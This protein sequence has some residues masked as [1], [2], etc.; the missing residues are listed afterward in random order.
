ML[1]ALPASIAFG[2]SIYAGAGLGDAGAGAVM[3][4]T[5]AAALGIVAP[6]VAR[7][8][9]LIS[10]PCAPAAAVLLALATQ[11]S[12][13]GVAAWQVPVLLGLT[14]L[15]AAFLQVLYGA[16]GGGRLIKFIPYQVVSGYMT[17]VGIIIVL[18]QLPKLLGLHSGTSLWQGV[19]SPL[20]WNPHAIAVGL[21]TMFAML[22]ALRL[23]H[24][25][26]GT[27]AGLTAGGLCYAGL[28]WFEPTLRT[29]EGNPLVI[30]ALQMSGE[31]LREAAQRLYA[32]EMIP[33]GTLQLILV[34][35]VTLSLL[36]S[37][38]TL[39]TCVVLDTITL[40]RHDAN[41]ELIGQGVGNALSCAFGGMPGAGTM[42]PTLVN[43]TS[44]GRTLR[45]GVIEGLL[46][47]GVLLALRDLIAWLP[48]PSLA[49]ILIV[50]AW[51]MMDKNMLRLL[52]YP[53]GR[54]DFAVI[55]GVIVVAVT[56]DLVAAALVGVVFAILLFIR[57]RM[58]EQ[59][60]RRKRYL[61]E[62]PSNTR[63][64][65]VEREVLTRLGHEAVVCELQ[66]D[67]F[68]GTAD[69]LFTLLEPDLH[70]ARYVLLDLRRVQ[71]MD[72]TA[73]HQ[74]SQIQSLLEKRGGRLLFSGMPSAQVD[75]RD[76][77][78]DLSKLEVIR[79]GQG[80]LV[81]DT[82]DGAQE[83]MEE[84]LLALEGVDGPVEVV[85]LLEVRDFPLF[86][87]MG[88]AAHEAL[89]G[90]MRERCV[91]AGE[92]IVSAGDEGDELFLI[93]RGRVTVLLP[94]AGGKRHHLS[95]LGAGEFFGELSF[96]DRS[97]R[98]ADVEARLHTDLYVLSRAAFDTQV[99]NLG[100]PSA[101]EFFARLAL[102]MAKRLRESDAEIR[103]LEER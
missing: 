91:T 27:L 95:T 78:M 30:G 94:L 12:M 9:G 18:G 40:N 6:L 87:G 4:A 41:R 28:A 79:D 51:R 10:A 83:W 39:K 45:S 47:L 53:A 76:F 11:L 59:V 66:G 84:Q 80:A 72:F 49:A 63:R 58:N 8:K 21:S 60:I 56:V 46:V 20:L 92:R 75:G 54:L 89:K 33:L 102:S 103:V 61:H 1:V 62:A 97:A 32:V 22:A 100:E 52:R 34:P 86:A 23:N 71:S 2:V 24:K 82:M 96:I 50:V 74:L 17:G 13:S 5:G 81:S 68:F 69:K 73:A 7:S 31:H 48:L 26:P 65:A 35:T 37:I 88:Y 55:T 77:E 29:L 44:G 16:L 25:I 98:T 90:C 3:G 57:A 101:G 67:L 14:G 64:S 42:G 85:D 15:L 70:R 38:D 99:E 36:L 43:V 19:I 93:R